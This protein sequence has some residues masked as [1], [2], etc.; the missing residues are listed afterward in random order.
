MISLIG[1]FSSWTGLSNVG[2]DTTGHKAIIG[3]Q[4]LSDTV[5]LYGVFLHTR[6]S[7]QFRRGKGH[8]SK[9]QN[10]KK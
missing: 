5:G 8:R 4:Q 2:S 10:T 7:R 3:R 1:A 6:E 9:Y